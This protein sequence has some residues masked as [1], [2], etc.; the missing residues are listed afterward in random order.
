MS[1]TMFET[2]GFK[3]KI[4]HKDH[5]PP[6]IHVEGRGI[7]VVFELVTLRCIHD[8]DQPSKVINQLRMEIQKRQLFL[9]EAWNEYQK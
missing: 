4:H 3:F 8:D 5:N 1:P 6:H 9:L 2:P 7:S